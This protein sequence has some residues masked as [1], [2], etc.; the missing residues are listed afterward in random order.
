MSTK[1]DNNSW[2]KEFLVMKFYSPSDVK[3]LNKGLKD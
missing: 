1:L 3:L 2:Q